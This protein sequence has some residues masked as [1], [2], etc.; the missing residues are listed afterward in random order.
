MAYKASLLALL[1]PL[2]LIVGTIRAGLLYLTRL[3]LL[4]LFSFVSAPMTIDPPTAT[5]D[6]DPPTI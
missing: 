4:T 2:P 5:A 3:K 1:K 6:A